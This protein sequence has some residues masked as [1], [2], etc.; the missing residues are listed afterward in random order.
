MYSSRHLLTNI[1]KHLKRHSGP[2]LFCKLLSRI[3]TDRLKVSMLFVFK[4]ENTQ[5][6]ERYFVCIF[7][8]H[9]HL[10]AVTDSL[11]RTKRWGF[12][13]CGWAKFV[14]HWYNMHCKTDIILLNIKHINKFNFALRYTLLGTFTPNNTR[15]EWYSRRNTWPCNLRAMLINQINSCFDNCNFGLKKQPM[16]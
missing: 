11:S 8:T 4:I 16:K 13:S 1:K 5:T 9:L 3:R 6:C 12:T 10:T 15:S 7:A 2:K 14:L